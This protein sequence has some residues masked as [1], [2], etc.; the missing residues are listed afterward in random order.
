MIFKALKIFWEQEEKLKRLY[1]IGSTMFEHLFI[2]AR[3][4]NPVENMMDR[5]DG[6]VITVSEYKRISEANRYLTFGKDTVRFDATS[7]KN[8]FRYR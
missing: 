7:E 8:F 4:N 6:K 2:L 1:I 3:G 5:V